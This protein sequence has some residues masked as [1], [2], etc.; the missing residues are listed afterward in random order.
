MRENIFRS[1]RQRHTYSQ[2]CDDREYTA[3]MRCVNV[4]KRQTETES[5][6]K[7]STKW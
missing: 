7:I 1:V 5:G 2:L 4:A 3:F 6:H